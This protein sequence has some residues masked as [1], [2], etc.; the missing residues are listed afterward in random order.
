MP[1]LLPCNSTPLERALAAGWRDE[2]VI[3]LRTLYNADTCPSRLLPYLAWAWSVDRWNNDWPEN[4]KRAAC[5]AAWFIHQ[6]KGT[7]GAL[8]R[9]V[10]PL[11]QLLKVTEWFELDPPGPPGTFSLEVGVLEG[12]ISDDMY[13]ELLW[14]IDDAKPVSRHVVAL[15][16]LLQAPGYLYLGAASMDGDTLT[17]YPLETEAVP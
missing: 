15:S 3:P 17:V 11:G 5:R 16:V 13:Q 14:L 4:A 6:R 2:P 10:E 1:D 7:L 12:G 8:R 9:A